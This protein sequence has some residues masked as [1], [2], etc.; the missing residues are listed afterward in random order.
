[1]PEL[2]SVLRPESSSTQVLKMKEMSRLARLRPGNLGNL[3]FLPLKVC[4]KIYAIVLADFDPPREMFSFYEVSFERHAENPVQAT[5]S[6][7]TAI[8]QT[9]RDVYRETFDLMVKENRFVHIRSVGVTSLFLLR[10]TSVPIV[11]A[12]AKRARSFKGY[13]L[14]IGLT[15]PPHGPWLPGG[16][17]PFEAMMLARDLEKLCGCLMDGCGFIPGFSSKLTMTLVLGPV[18]SHGHQPTQRTGYEDFE[19]LNQYFS[20]KTQ[21]E[22][23]QPFRC[24]M[25]GFRNVKVCGRVSDDIA[26]STMEDMTSSNNKWNNPDKVLVSTCG[27]NPFLF[28]LEEALREAWE[29]MNF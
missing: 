21:Q 1:M 25:H 12:N 18:V 2:R 13:V 17:G 22:L 15:F 3:G 9:S 5:H 24:N 29:L 20:E 26:R 11:T 4:N 10:I 16:S 7:H 23:L 8:L 14:D 28:L 19:S 6:I 27:M